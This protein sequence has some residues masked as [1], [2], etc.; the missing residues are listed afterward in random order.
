M[1]NEA[2]VPE[3]ELN[4]FTKELVRRI[5]I[6]DYVWV[7]LRNGRCVRVNI[8]KRAHG[9]VFTSPDEGFSRKSWAV[10]GV[11]NIAPELDIVEIVV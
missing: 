3:N 8:S 11:S 9:S 5:S 4:D 6:S 10:N 7:E 2:I 1:R